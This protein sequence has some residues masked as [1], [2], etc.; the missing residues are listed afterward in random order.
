MYYLSL[1]F[2]MA[3]ALTNTM[4]NLGIHSTVD[5][6]IYHQL[7]MDIEE[8]QEYEEDAGLGLLFSLDDH[9]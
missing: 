9:L 4:V 8:L 5:E 7:G 2:Y 3:R 6:A 1:E